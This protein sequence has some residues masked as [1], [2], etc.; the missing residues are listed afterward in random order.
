MIGSVSTNRRANAFA[1]ALEEQD[2][3]GAGSGVRTEGAVLNGSTSPASPEGPPGE[4]DQ[5]MML[6]LAREL[7]ALPKPEL[8][9]EVKT[10]H[11]A[12]LIAAMETHLAEGGTLVPEQRTRSRKGAHRAVPLG[13]LS[14]LRPRSRLTKGLAAGGLTVGVAAGAFSGVAA[15]STNALP[16]DTLY[17]LKRGMED[18]KLDLA[19]G[20]TDRGR[21]H[22]DHA[23]TRLHEARRLME[24]GRSGP[25]DHEALGDVR[26]ALSSMRHDASEG[27]RLLSQA[28]ERD[29]KI[30]PMQSLSSFAKTHRSGWAQLRQKLPAQL[31]DVGDEVSSVFDAIDD[32]VIPIRSLLPPEPDSRMSEGRPETGDHT[33]QE[34]GT[35]PGTPSSEDQPSDGRTADSEPPSPSNSNPE[36]R[37]DGLL[38]GS[39]LL[40]PPAQESET[41]S[42]GSGKDSLQP[43]PPDVTIPPLLPGGLP[44]LGLEVD[45][46]K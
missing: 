22:L 32:E 7:D 28:Y 4:A 20:D 41:D 17:G 39:G 16:G 27:H 3:E 38:G 45:D 18:L 19:G 24:R 1:Q 12:R 43:P 13:S 29:G 8:D 34:P 46:D 40:D 25:L 42:S 31:Q 6:A 21:V 2:P 44:G 14:K 23:S 5:A 9:H 35:Q 37:E 15:A 26:R 33:G 30:A 10:V 11:R 36:E